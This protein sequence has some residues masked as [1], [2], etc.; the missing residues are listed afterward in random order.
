M[1]Q[2]GDRCKSTNGRISATSDHLFHINPRQVSVSTN[3]P[4]LQ[5]PSIPFK[6]ILQFNAPIG[7][8]FF[9]FLSYPFFFF[10]NHQGLSKTMFSFT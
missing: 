9:R 2:R 7:I 10:S 6:K 3:N 5:I 1:G 8:Q 4:L